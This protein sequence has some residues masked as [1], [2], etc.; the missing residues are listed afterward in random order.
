MRVR[1]EELRAAGATVVEA[2]PAT[3]WQIPI[4]AL[5][6]IGFLPERLA[7]EPPRASSP[8]PTSDTPSVA[9]ILSST[10]TTAAAHV[11]DLQHG[12]LEGGRATRRRREDLH[13]RL[14]QPAPLGPA[15]ADVLTRLLMWTPSAAPDSSPAMG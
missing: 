9:D 4:P 14:G 3:G 2:H 15:N 13:T 6:A 5:L 8:Q 10:P 12:R 1:R 11:S 7:L